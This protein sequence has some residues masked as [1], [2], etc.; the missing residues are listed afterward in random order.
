MREY[1]DGLVAVPRNRQSGTVKVFGTPLI[2]R[3]SPSFLVYPGCELP[4]GDASGA[5]KSQERS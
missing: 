3:R 5:G 4:V 1:S 2:R